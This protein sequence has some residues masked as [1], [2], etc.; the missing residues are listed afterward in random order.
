MPNNAVDPSPSSEGLGDSEG[1][2]QAQGRPKE[3]LQGQS[4][5]SLSEASKGSMG[6]LGM[7]AGAV[8]WLPKSSSR[9]CLTVCPMS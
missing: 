8:P 4:V 5:A 7:V 6:H 2:L 9:A 1:Q 3:A